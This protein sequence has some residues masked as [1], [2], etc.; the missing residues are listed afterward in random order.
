M[1]RVA[2]RFGGALPDRKDLLGLP[3][4]HRTKRLGQ[5]R[6][7]IVGSHT[8]LTGRQSGRHEQRRRQ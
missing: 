8:P 1:A 4:K 7:C 5:D 3:L 6:C 2:A